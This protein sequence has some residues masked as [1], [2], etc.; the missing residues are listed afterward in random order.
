MSGPLNNED[1]AKRGLAIDT[2]FAR[3]LEGCSQQEFESFH[4]P[5]C[6][7]ALSLHVH[8]GLHSFFVRCMVSSVHLGRHGQI[9][10]A[11]AWWQQHVGAGW[12]SHS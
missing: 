4:C 2:I 3:L 1:T 5:V 7:G 6:S 10:S 9:D 12:Y 8:P 11:P